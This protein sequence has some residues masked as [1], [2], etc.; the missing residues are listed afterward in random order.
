MEVGKFVL[1]LF[2]FY[3]FPIISLVENKTY[4]LVKLQDN[5]GKYYELSKNN[6]FIC[7]LNCEIICFWD[8]LSKFSDEVPKNIENDLP[9]NE[10]VAGKEQSSKAKTKVSIVIFVNKS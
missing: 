9:I 7:N 4:L 10:S 8:F 2:T 5:G 1:V 3:S 6:C